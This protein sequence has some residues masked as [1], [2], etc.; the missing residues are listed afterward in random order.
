MDAP[1]RP[2]LITPYRVAASLLVAGAIFLVVFAFQS[3]PET[4]P[5]IHDAVVRAVSP[6]PGSFNPHQQIIFIEIDPTY[7]GVISQLN[8]V[9]I[10]PLQLQKIPDVL[11][12]SYDPGQPG[13]ATGRLP[14]GHNCA[15]AHFWKVGQ[16]PDS[17]RDFSWCFNLQ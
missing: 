5:V 2:R 16:P 17:G 8:G 11:R 4:A 14:A 6:A 15:T 1:A 13:S 10:P 12:I 3:H 7:D 9:F